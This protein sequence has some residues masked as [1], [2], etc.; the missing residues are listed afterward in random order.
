MTLVHLSICPMDYY[1]AV[2]RS[3]LWWARSLEEWQRQF[4]ERKKL[5]S[6]GSR[7]CDCINT[8]VTRLRKTEREL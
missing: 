8:R 6:K 1:P 7:R 4:A 5:I 3:A 2:K